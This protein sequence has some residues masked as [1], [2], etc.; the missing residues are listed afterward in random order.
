ILQDA[1]QRY[2]NSRDPGLSAN[3]LSSSTLHVLLFTAILFAAAAKLINF[4]PKLPSSHCI[5]SS[6]TLILAI[7]L[8]CAF[9]S[10]AYLY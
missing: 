7:A 5:R 4:L 1:H 3:P 2:G 6:L 8:I 9:A 10:L